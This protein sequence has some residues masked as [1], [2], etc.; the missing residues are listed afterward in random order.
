[1]SRLARPIDSP[2]INATKNPSTKQASYFA[3][4]LINGI[5]KILV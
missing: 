2:T 4:I 5:C 1:M 3:I